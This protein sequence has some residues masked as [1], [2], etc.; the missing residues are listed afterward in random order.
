MEKRNKLSHAPQ[1]PDFYETGSTRPPKSRGGLVAFLL[2]LVIFLGGVSSALGLLNIQL[3]SQQTNAPDPSSPV[4]LYPSNAGT[5]ETTIGAT[6]AT[7]PLPSGKVELELDQSP[8]SVE[9]VPQKGGLSLQAIYSGAIDSVVS[10][11]CTLEDG[12]SSGTG[13]VLSKNGYIVTN[14]HVVEDAASIQVRLTDDRVLPANIVG[15]DIV[16]DLAVLIV[17]A[18]DLSPADFGDSSALRVGDAVAAIGDPFGADFRGTMTDGIVSAI[19]Q[20][21]SVSGRPMTL[22]QTNAVLN[23]GNSGGPLLNCYGQVIGINTMKIGAFTDNDGVEGI[24]FA[25]PSTTVKEIVDQLICQGFVDGR[26]SLGIQGQEVSYYYQKFYHLP[27]GV[28]ITEVQR[29]GSAHTAGLRIGD[30]ILGLNGIRVSDMDTLAT[31]LYAC[32]AGE[33]VTLS[34]Y[35]TGIQQNVTLT[36][37]EA[38]G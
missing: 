12:S 10:I 22:I 28:L 26:P 33:S 34:I 37:G 5:T 2:I 17:N 21:I 14:A 6:Q 27:A 18:S 3:L 9:N 25:I 32:A 19:N 15:A 4:M 11:S 7:V 35:R 38:N 36:L 16:S 31:A 24:G 30:I 8:E 23:S 1:E 20:D 29:G 13:V